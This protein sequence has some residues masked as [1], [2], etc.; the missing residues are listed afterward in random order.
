M[1]GCKATLKTVLPYFKQR[2]QF[3]KP[4]SELGLIRAK[5]A[6]IAARAFAAE[7][8]VYRTAGLMDRAIARLDRADPQYDL[9]TVETVEEFTIECWRLISRK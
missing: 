1:G 4:L 2:Q 8:M 9:R 5:L 7:S 6:D 3:G